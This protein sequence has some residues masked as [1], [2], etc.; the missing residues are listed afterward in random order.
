MAGNVRISTE[1]VIACRDGLETIARLHVQTLR[2]ET[3]VSINANVSTTRDAE[4]LTDIASAIPVLWAQNVRNFALKDSLD[5]AASKSVLAAE[6]RTLFAIQRTVVS[7]N[8][9]SK[10]TTVTSRCLVNFHQKKVSLIVVI[11]IFLY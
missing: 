1:S 11:F 3:T 8:Q 5:Q 10:V 7:V 9:D 2:G 4:N 6:N